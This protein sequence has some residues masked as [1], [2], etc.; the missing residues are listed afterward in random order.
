MD[1]TKKD[2]I[3]GKMEMKIREEEEKRRDERQK[4][5]EEAQNKKTEI[6]RQKKQ[7]ELDWIW[8]TADQV[9]KI[10]TTKN[11]KW[12]E[13]F[14]VYFNFSNFIGEYRVM[15]RRMAE[16]ASLGL[17]YHGIE[18]REGKAFVKLMD[19][20]KKDLSEKYSS[21]KIIGKGEHGYDRFEEEINRIKASISVAKEKN[22]A[23]DELGHITF[24]T[25][26][27][28]GICK[29]DIPVEVEMPLKQALLI[30]GDEEFVPKSSYGKE[31]KTSKSNVTVESIKKALRD[32]FEK[33]LFEK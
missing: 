29:D 30:G 31:E 13:V 9:K 8:K 20:K 26:Y 1:L 11:S 27:A 21:Y 10:L 5:E 22:E 18:T 28:Y 6:E 12:D 25:R 4:E 2:I 7:E 3:K 16:I 14:L 17:Y 24:K 32:A 33:D 15:T 23:A 19:S